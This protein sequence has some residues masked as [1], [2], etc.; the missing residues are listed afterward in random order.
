MIAE[1]ATSSAGRGAP[2]GGGCFG[3]PPPGHRALR[4]REVGRR[5]LCGP[6]LSIEVHHP[7]LATRR[8]HDGETAMRAVGSASATTV[9]SPFALVPGLSITSGGW[10][11][12]SNRL[13][14]GLPCGPR[15]RTIRR[16]S[17][18]R[19]RRGRTMPATP[20]SMITQPATWMFR[21]EGCPRTAKARI[22]PSAT[23][24]SPLA[25]LMAVLSTG[26]ARREMGVRHAR[27]HPGG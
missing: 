21:K 7:G 1:K 20:I 6:P 5:S 23:S 10:C 26:P 15:R 13:T 12:S 3:R 25:V 27:G 24:I 22:A 18:P 11:A 9:V 8:V 19:P 17:H 14:T 4:G 2:G 16:R